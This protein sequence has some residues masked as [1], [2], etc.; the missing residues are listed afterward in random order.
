MDQSRISEL[1]HLAEIGKL[2]GGFI[3]DL[4]NHVTVMSL[5]L[6]RIEESLLKEGERI[7]EHAAESARVRKNVNYFIKAVKKHMRGN[8]INCYFSPE[9]KLKELIEIFK[10]KAEK[11]H[12]SLELYS[13]KSKNA[14]KSS[15]LKLYGSRVRFNQLFSNLISNSIDAFTS[16]ENVSERIVCI[17]IKK[18]G[19]FIVIS[20]IDNGKGINPK[21]L[22][23][24]FD[25]F[26]TTKPTGKGSGLGLATAK[27]IAEK[28]F[29]GS[30]KV[31]SVLGKGSRFSVS[32][33]LRPNPN[34]PS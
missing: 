20:V 15:N 18:K 24:I 12:V 3:H 14:A 8:D 1:E 11:E 5:S 22:E 27:E 2:S 4:A 13:E 9:K 6:D 21:I 23:K 26:F 19:K 31:R 17:K 10:Y 34:T 30:I 25:R 7:K 33:P 16:S 28:E 29:S 32:I